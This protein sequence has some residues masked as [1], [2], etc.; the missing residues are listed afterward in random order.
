MADGTALDGAST[1]RIRWVEAVRGS[2]Q[3]TFI[4]RDTASSH[5]RFGLKYAM[6]N[7]LKCAPKKTFPKMHLDFWNNFFRR[8]N[9]TARVSQLCNR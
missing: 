4:G 1:V 8:G 7:V 5:A 3:D 2:N 6:C 9:L